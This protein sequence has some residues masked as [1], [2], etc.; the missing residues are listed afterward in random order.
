MSMRV[1]TRDAL[2]VLKF[3]LG[4][5]EQGGYRRSARAPWRPQF[6]FEDSPTCMNYHTPEERGECRGC[7]L[8]HFVPP[9]ARG[10]KIPCRHVP[11]TATGETLDSLY[12]HSEQ[13][14]IEEAVVGWLRTTIAQLERERDAHRGEANDPPRSISDTRPARPLYG[15]DPPKCANPECAIAFHWL[16]GGKFFRFRSI[17]EPGNLTNSAAQALER[18]L[19]LPC[20][21]HHEVKHYWLCEGC[22]RVLTLAYNEGQGVVV[23]ALRPELPVSRAKGPTSSHHS[24]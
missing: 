17:D 15:T 3:E 13:S 8:M 22:A 6:I 21:G 19:W 9:E 24:G 2:D 1:D 11:L 23:K 18:V 5:L 20:L 7:V 14:E 4:F 16:A 12:R 10:E